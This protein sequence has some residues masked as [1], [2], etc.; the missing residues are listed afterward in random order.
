MVIPDEVSEKERDALKEAIKSTKKI[1]KRLRKG[2]M[3]LFKDPDE[4]DII[5]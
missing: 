5:H 1:I 4:W 2:D 3:S